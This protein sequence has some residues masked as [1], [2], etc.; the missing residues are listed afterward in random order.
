MPQI[1]LEARRSPF[2]IAVLAAAMLLAAGS[3]VR[4]QQIVALVDGVPITALDVEQRTKF[5]KMSTQKEPAR[6]YVL[7]GLINE[8]LEIKEAHRFSIDVPDE[9]VDKSFANMASH[10]G[11]D[12]QRLAQILTQGGASPDTLKHRLRAELAW[13]NL[14]R[15]RYK[16]SLQI[17]DSDVEAELQLHKPEEAK[18]VGYEYIL[19]PVVLIVPRGS[20]DAAYEARKHDADSLRARFQSC[21]DGIAFARELREVAVRDQIPKSSADLPAPLRELLDKTEIGHLTPPEQTAEGIQMFALCS[22]KETTAD[23][24]SKR[25]ARDEIFQKK[26]GAKAQRY[27]QQ[28]RRAAM[29]EYK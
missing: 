18:Q 23:T 29:I 20:P 13:T 15:G 12:S 10:M 16:S 8:I 17:A 14:V 7:D 21:N 26:F 28:L 3:G 24:P 11:M 6:Q 27:L 5:I 1:P 2:T 22:K 25:Q 9:E 4:A 19:R